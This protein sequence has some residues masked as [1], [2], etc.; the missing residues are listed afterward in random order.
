MFYMIKVR[1]LIVAILFFQE[2][3]GQ[4]NLVPAP[5]DVYIEKKSCENKQG[6]GYKLII[7]M[8]ASDTKSKDSEQNDYSLTGLINLPDSVKLLIVGLLLQYKNDTA[9]VCKPV[10]SYGYIAYENTCKGQ[11]VSGY[12]SISIEALYLIN[13]LCFPNEFSFCYCFP[14][15]VDTI[16]G[17]EINGKYEDIRNVFTFYESWFERTKKAGL[18]DKIFP[19]NDGRYMWYGGKKMRDAVD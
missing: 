11:P 10:S 3:Y 5:P 14:V 1:L 4:T 12:Y 6:R 2:M 15:L 17:K 18:I 8:S 9:I 19:F 16:T 7:H 13:R